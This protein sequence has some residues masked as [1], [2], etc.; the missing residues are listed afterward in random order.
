MFGAAF[1]PVMMGFDQTMPLPMSDEASTTVT[2]IGYCKQLGIGT[3]KPKWMI[4]RITVVG[5]VTKPEYAEGDNKFEHVWD[6]RATLNYS[7]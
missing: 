6:D 5:T 7:R 1:A 2:Y 3:N 4:L